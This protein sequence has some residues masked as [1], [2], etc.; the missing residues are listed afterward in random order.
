MLSDR[1]HGKISVRFLMR[2]AGASI[3]E[4]EARRAI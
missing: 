3:T 4:S 1:D 2:E